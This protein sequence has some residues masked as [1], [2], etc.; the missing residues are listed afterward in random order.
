VNQPIRFHLLASGVGRE[1]VASSCRTFAKFCDLFSF[2]CVLAR[3][4]NPLSIKIAGFSVIGD[5]TSG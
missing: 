3:D 4:A 1:S 2:L 5:N